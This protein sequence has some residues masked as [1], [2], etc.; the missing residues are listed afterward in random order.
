MDDRRSHSPRIHQNRNLRSARIAATRRSVPRLLEPLEAPAP[1]MARRV[2][3]STSA[4]F[5]RFKIDGG[6]QRG[7]DLGLAAE[8]REAFTPQTKKFE[9]LL[10]RVVSP[11]KRAPALGGRAHGR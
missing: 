6:E 5:N 8:L 11:S 3:F 4:I 1:P 2:N 10:G 7:I 9:R